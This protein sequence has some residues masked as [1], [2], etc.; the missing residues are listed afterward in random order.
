MLVLP[1]TREAEAGDGEYEVSPGK[2]KETL[3]QMRIKTNRAVGVA[4]GLPSE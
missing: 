1:A 2:V 4:G 3:S